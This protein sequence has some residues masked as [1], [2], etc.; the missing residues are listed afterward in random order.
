MCVKSQTKLTGMTEVRQRTKNTAGYKYL[1]DGR[2][3]IGAKLLSIYI[4]ECTG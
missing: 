4:S 2:R 3:Y 1:E